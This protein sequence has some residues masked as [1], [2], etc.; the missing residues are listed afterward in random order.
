MTSRPRAADDFGTIRARI[1]EPRRERAPVVN[2]DMDQTPS[3]SRL[4]Y[5]HRN[6]DTQPAPARHLP[7]AVMR[8]IVG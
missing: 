3:G 7:R 2:D 5:R 1:G 4:Y 6:G 8:R